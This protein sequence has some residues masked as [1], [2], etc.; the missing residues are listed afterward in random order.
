VLILPWNLQPEI[1]RQMA[2]V[3]DWGGKFVVAVPAMRVS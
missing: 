1:E 2:Q 3:R